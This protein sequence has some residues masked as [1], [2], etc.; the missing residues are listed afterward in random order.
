MVDMG[1]TARCYITKTVSLTQPLS[2]TNNVQ[3][4]TCMGMANGTITLDVK[5]GQAPYSFS[6]DAAPGVSVNSCNQAALGAGT[7]RV[8]VTDNRGCTFEQIITVPLLY[9]L[10]LQAAI[11][12]AECFGDSNGAIYLSVLNGSGSYT[13]HWTKGGFNA[14]T[15]DITNVEAG[16]YRVTVSDNVLGC[17]ITGE[18]T[19][20]EPS[21]PIAVSID[22]IVHNDCFGDRRGAISVTVTGGT[23][24]YT[25]HWGGPGILAN[26]STEDQTGLRGGE[27][28]LTVVD[29]RGCELSNYGPITVLEPNEPVKLELLNVTPVTANGLSNGAITIQVSGGSGNYTSITW[30]HD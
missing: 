19:V 30:V 24:P 2:V 21:D 4:E 15:K 29:A 16:T 17:T 28:Y 1:T 23:A 25:F 8:V 11:D 14:T 6:W 3:P 10:E 5:G 20:D 22:D 27:Y 13:Y 26:P 7:Y 9:S 12:H 18:Y